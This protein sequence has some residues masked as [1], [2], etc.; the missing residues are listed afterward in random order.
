MNVKA[1]FPEGMNEIFVNG[2]HQWDY[3]QQ[4]QIEAADLPA[5][6]E[7]HF[8]CPTM[9]EAI[10]RTC[11]VNTGSGTATVTIPDICLEQTAPITAWVYQIGGA[12]GTTIKIIKMI[13]TPRPRPANS[14]DAEAIE[15]NRYTE[16]ISAV[17]SQVASLQAGNVVVKRA[18]S[19]DNSSTATN[20][21]YASKAN[22]ATRAETSDTSLFATRADF[23]SDDITKGTIEA[24]LT[25][26]GFK[27]GAFEI[28]G[29][30][31]SITPTIYTN[32][33][34]KCGKYAI[35]NLL[36]QFILAPVQ[37]VKI[38]IPEDF[39]PKGAVGVTLTV[40][41]AARECTFEP[42]GS[43]NIQLENTIIYNS[44]IIA[45]NNFGWELAEAT[46]YP[47]IKFTVYG[48]TCYA[49][50]GM[51]WREYINSPY[52][53][54]NPRI[55]LHNDSDQFVRAQTEELPDDTFYIVDNDGN[56]VHPD[57]PIYNDYG[58]GMDL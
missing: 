10:V 29:D 44:A 5:M 36:F 2:L 13:V 18:L 32:T 57:D 40:D 55:F 26:L 47:T 21:T 22:L 53:T 41:G 50:N 56:S 39:K 58:Y 4:L 38:V 51:T 33:I 12:S 3:G 43:L 7:V 24:R 19:A 20:A 49:E 30:F 25:S 9:T 16:F 37:S 28:V 42:D 8:S 14:M 48:H 35:G 23:A 34:K 54:G 15:P 52:N 17:N 45:I 1:V 46:V 27:Q 31:G 11:S 6:V